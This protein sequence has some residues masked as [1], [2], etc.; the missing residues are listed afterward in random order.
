MHAT[1]CGAV[2]PIQQ[3]WNDF[4]ACDVP[5]LWREHP[6]LSECQSV[7]GVGFAAREGNDSVLIA[8]LTLLRSGEQQAGLV[9]L[10]GVWSRL[11]WHAHGRGID[12]LDD[13]VAPL[14]FQL[15]TYPL[16]R[17]P[18]SV[19]QNLVLDTI[20]EHCRASRERPVAPDLLENWSPAPTPSGTDLTGD[21]VLH[22]A[23]R[24]GVITDQSARVLHSVYL[25][26]MSS[27][28]AAVRH[29]TTETAIRWRCSASV[30][31]MAAQRGRLAA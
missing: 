28:V 31:K 1:P 30:K 22:R 12:R 23:T 16:D 29:A 21:V 27:R 4:C 2:A 5:A 8:L 19:A 3:W 24:L 17:R 25:E 15:V 18:R 14:W 20:K 26:G 10:W 13:L 6:S 9:A 11:R 7:A